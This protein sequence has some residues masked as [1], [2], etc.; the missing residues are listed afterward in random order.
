MVSVPYLPACFSYNFHSTHW[1]NSSWHTVFQYELYK[2]RFH[3]AFTIVVIWDLLQDIS[4]K[5][6]LLFFLLH[7]LPENMFRT[8]I[9][10]YKYTYKNMNPQ[11]MLYIFINMIF[12]N[13]F[14]IFICKHNWH[15]VIL[16]CNNYSPYWVF[17]YRNRDKEE[18]CRPTVQSMALHQSPPRLAMANAQVIMDY[19]WHLRWWH[20]IKIKNDLA[21]L[22]L[23]LL[24]ARG[25]IWLLAR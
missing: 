3:Y 19:G 21:L 11:T 10:T 17:G 18:F 5:C 1:F 16:E 7:F 25:N 23:Y 8:H 4:W 2:S 13:I 22:S 14:N 12:M 20:L 9:H 15:I 24:A 6:M